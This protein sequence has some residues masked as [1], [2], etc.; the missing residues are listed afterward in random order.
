MAS[1]SVSRLWVDHFHT[2]VREFPHRDRDIRNLEG[3][4]V[5]SRPPL[6][7]EPAYRSVFCESRHEF[8]TSAT[9][10]EVN[11]LHPL[12]VHAAPQLDARA[13]EP[14]VGRDRLVEVL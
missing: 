11:G 5:H 14:L 3:D 6:C 4:V 10:L 9:D 8:D 1:E 13:E 7:K 12:L 2:V